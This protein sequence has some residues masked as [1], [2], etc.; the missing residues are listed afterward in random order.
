LAGPGRKGISDCPDEVT[1]SR[2]ETKSRTRIGGLRSTGTKAT[3]RVGHIREPQAELDRAVA[4]RRRSQRGSKL[5]RVA[6]GDDRAIC[7]IFVTLHF[8]WESL[9]EG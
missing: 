1:L 7:V 5:R 2:K 8:F 9:R 3:T 4:F 6:P